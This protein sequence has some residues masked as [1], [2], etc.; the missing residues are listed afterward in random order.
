VP[1]REIVTCRNGQVTAEK[2][3]AKEKLMENNE[4][5]GN[6]V[7]SKIMDVYSD[8]SI[9]SFRV[10]LEAKDVMS[11][12]VTT[13]SP[14]ETVVLATKVMSENNISCIIA[15]DNA[16][17]VGILTETDVLKRAV[18]QEKDF[19]KL[20][21]GE[22]MSSP[23]ET[24][25][26]DLSVLE[27]GRIMEDKHIKRLPIL[28]EK[29]LVGIVTQTDLIRV[30]TSYGMWRDVEELMSK[31][32]A[33]IQRNATV[34][35]A[36]K[37]MASRNISCIIALKADELVGVLTEKDILK[38]VVALQK[39]P[40]HI[41]IEQIMSSPVITLPPDYSVF[42]A[43]RIMEKMDIRRLVIMM[44]KKLLG[45][46]TQTDIFRAVKKKLQDEEAELSKQNEF[47][48]NILEC[49]THPFYVIDAN[50]Y[51]IKMAN[52]AGQMG[53]LPEKATCYMLS[54]KRDKPCNGS[55]HFCPLKEIK[56]TGQP[57]TV[58]HV[59]YDKDGNPRDVEVHGYPVFDNE[60]NVT[61]IIEYC[62]DITERKQTEE[63]QRH[64]GEQL[65]TLIEVA[66]ELATTDSFDD[67]CRRAV[68]LGRSRLG[69]DRLGIWF[70]SDEPDT[71]VGSFGVDENGNI[72]DERGKKNKLNPDTPDGR[73][74]LGK[75]P[76]VL[77][78]EL[79]LTNH[80]GQVVGQAAQVFAGIW[81]GEKVIGHIS[82]DNRI[83]KDAI[84]EQQCELLRLF[85]AT[86]GYLG[87]RNRAEGNLK[88]AKEQAEKAWAE[89]EQVNLQLEASVE[90][91]KLL[92]QQATA[93]DQAKSEFLTN[94]SHEIRTPMNTIIGFSE[95][96]AEEKLTDE[97]RHHVDIIQ[98]SGK[99][100]LQLINDILDFSKIEAGKLNIEITD[101]SLEEMLALIE[102][103]MR[104]MAIEKELA[105]EVLQCNQLP[106]QIRTDPLRLRQC[107][108][109]LIN[110]AVK[111]TEKGHVYLNV[112][113]QEIN[114]EPCIRFDVE[115]TGIGI[116]PEKQK[117]IFE[118]FAQ[119]DGSS[120]RKYGGTG[121]GLAIT[122][123]LA[124]LLGGRFSLTSEVAKGSV[125]SITIPAG[126]DV[127]SQ[128]LFN[129]YDS[130][131]KL[132]RKPDAPEQPRFSG[133]A[134]VAEDSISNQMLVKLLL[135][136]MGLQVTTAQDGKEAV[137]KALSQPF[138][139]IFMD[140]QMPNMNGYDAT[141]ALR[142][143]E[144]TI[145]IIALT[146]HA[147]KDDD[148]KCIDAG[149][150]D[151]LTKPI[152]SKKLFETICKYLPSE[153]T[154]LSQKIDSVKS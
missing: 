39:N 61:Q 140:I 93:A 146:A 48:N 89:T 55:D 92:A 111:F 150:N 143:K 120:T 74:L 31:D 63:S 102:S 112:S 32:V 53:K 36:A 30:L 44:D 94:M 130:V 59:H 81:D 26:S 151:Y 62:L 67:L 149:C 96:L 41:K 1:A 73:V 2:M 133:R 72:C 119:V 52:S 91:A 118:A 68:E 123:Q 57:V 27:A 60:G 82:M 10:L 95:V 104:P 42:S 145:P 125:F 88:Y 117:S 75:E 38:R 152:S 122:K 115:D 101:C 99:N 85:A 66:N 47:L 50:D 100:L 128:P 46:V 58:E 43:S 25:S 90:Q 40:A 71:I 23:V 84:T 77:E 141:K 144:V 21:V 4:R 54:H 126:V 15:V 110:N 45:I 97:Q 13:I 116:P 136:K 6:L 9:T 103:L 11:R 135:E 49:L 69:F 131:N 83:I 154:A 37:I 16:S 153:S 132:S 113:L 33:G 106:A 147:M 121:L 64:F 8:C 7:K 109:N 107:L 79:P 108:T 28:K 65:I 134:L 51:T 129:K 70:R 137:S 127:K 105:F 148:K 78:S 34:V 20:R 114:S 56:K 19:N 5:F 12:D 86:I 98:E 124:D 24:I 80:K 142:K 18:A 3:G 87:T 138:D 17:V 139:M 22:I 35:D 14:D 76:F 29:R